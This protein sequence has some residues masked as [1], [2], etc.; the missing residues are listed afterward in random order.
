MKNKKYL[1]LLLLIGCF[2]TV[3]LLGFIYIAQKYDEDHTFKLNNAKLR[4]Q[5]ILKYPTLSKNPFNWKNDFPTKWIL[6]SVQP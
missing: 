4:S 6:D 2:L 5:D 3:F 1:K